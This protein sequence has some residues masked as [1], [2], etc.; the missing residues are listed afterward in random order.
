M[1]K[2]GVLCSM[3]FSY[4]NVPF[5]ATRG[6]FRDSLVILNDGQMTRMTPSP[7]FSTTQ[8]GRRLTHGIR[9]NM[10]KACSTKEGAL[11][12]EVLRGT[13]TTGHKGPSQ[14]GISRQF[15]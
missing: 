12:Y 1:P 2:N 15:P 5:E 9:F 4:I 6:L 3:K 13:D 11:I 7:K 8:A 14:L 10:H